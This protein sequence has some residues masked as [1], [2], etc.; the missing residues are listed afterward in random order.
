MWALILITESALFFGWYNIIMIWFKKKLVQV[1]ENKR[2]RRKT[3]NERRN[4]ILEKRIDTE[5]EDSH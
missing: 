5:G 3:E 1:E 2:Q 4:E